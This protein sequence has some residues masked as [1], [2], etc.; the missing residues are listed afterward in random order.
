MVLPN[1]NP[2]RTNTTNERPANPMAL[3]VLAAPSPA[4]ASFSAKYGPKTIG[5]HEMPT[6]AAPPPGW[7]LKNG[8]GQWASS[9]TK[10]KM[11]T[12]SVMAAGMAM[13]F[14]METD[15]VSPME[16]SLFLGSYDQSSIITRF[17]V[18]RE[19]FATGF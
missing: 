5:S 10:R 18:G 12:T 11:V 9:P 19:G 1:M 7:A 3:P 8:E 14:K 2:A 17:E 13:S 6:I 16:S 4:S 15:F